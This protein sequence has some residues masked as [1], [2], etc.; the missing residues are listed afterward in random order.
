[1]KQLQQSQREQLNRI[2]WSIGLGIA[3]LGAAVLVFGWWLDIES[4][5]RIRANWASLKANTAIGFVL[6]GA[7]L[8]TGRRS[9]DRTP[10]KLHLV[11]AALL[12]LLGATNV[13]QHLTDINLHI[14]E[15]L[16][17]D[18]SPLAYN[19]APGRM[20][21]ATA[22]SF[23]FFGLAFCFDW[24]RRDHQR[25]WWR[26]DVFLCGVTFVAYLEMLG[27]ANG[28]SAGFGPSSYTGMAFHTVVTLIAAT[29][30]AFFLR[31]QSTIMEIATSPF[32]GSTVVKRFFPVI[33]VLPVFL[34]I[35]K[36]FGIQ[37]EQLSP[38]YGWSLL[39]G[40]NASL[41]IAVTLY[42][43]GRLNEIE[44]NRNKTA[45]LAAKKMAR[46]TEIADSANRAKSEF[47]RN[48]SHEFRT[49]LN[50]IMGYSELLLDTSKD[51]KG[52]QQTFLQ[53]IVRNGQ[54][55]SRL[56]DDILDL[57]KIEA[58]KLVID[59][60]KVDLRAAIDQV[61]TMFS[62]TA[63]DKH[64]TFV[65]NFEK[66]APAVIDTDQTR[67]R[68]ILVNI[69]GNA[70]KFSHQGAI[71]ISASSREAA[72]PTQRMLKLTVRDQGIGLNREQQGLL[73]QPFSQA[74]ASTTR[75]YGGT[76]LGL[77]LSRKLAMALGGNV[78]LVESEP[79]KGSCFEI[80][81]VYNL[82][83]HIETPKEVETHTPFKVQGMKILIAEDVEDNRRLIH[84]ILTHHGMEVDMTCDGKE[85]V[86]KATNNQY[87]AVLMDIQMPVLD[88]YAA[89][90][91]LREIG[92]RGP[93]IAVT[94]HAMVGERKKAL[95][96]GCDEHLTKPINFDKLLQYLTSVPR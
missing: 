11:C 51:I 69:I 34:S 49:P 52:D 79:N 39:V 43:A 50:A 54:T 13:F 47:L 77:A 19:I 36:V 73:F 28:L 38:E 96:A 84:K 9:E 5:R 90:T 40:L 56:I 31:P 83:S 66:T 32:A 78:A 3:I 42:T 87:D 16:V 95:A 45:S 67:L 25:S 29:F 63:Q 10:N 59:I 89:T 7:L 53:T 64:L 74:D 23:M 72:L 55:L 33:L 2:A 61:T 41:M 86:E 46:A 81:L 60:E 21:L 91:R 27:Y 93:I 26:F 15:L 24:F 6:L 94:A 30:A 14:D 8:M 35:A 20:A 76:G 57:A 4:V 68:Q 1:M 48:L 88:G 92:Y 85:A 12:G 80:S 62:R 70:V 71:L 75:Q 58:G 17:R 18:F 22:I 65:V 37:Y 82:N 44:S